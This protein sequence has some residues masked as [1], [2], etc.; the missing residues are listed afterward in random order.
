MP[1]YRMPHDEAAGG[2]DMTITRPKS[3]RDLA[4]EELRRRI[5]DGRIELGRGL[6]ENTLASE[7]GI[8]KTPIREALLHLKLEGLVDIQ[9]QRGTF[10]FRMDAAQVKQLSTMREILELAAIETA[11]ENDPAELADALTEVTGR[12]QRAIEAGDAALYRTLDG[13]FHQ[14]IVDLAGNQYLADAFQ[15]I[16]F[17]IQAL[18]NRLSVDPVLNRT[19]LDEHEGIVRRIRD[20]RAGGARKLMRAHIRGTADRY[21]GI[22]SVQRGAG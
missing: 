11:A 8:S 21:I 4:V 20:G 13:D 22:L 5:I 2:S 10:V 14:R 3:L 12:M 9:P 1:T 19:S 16:A 6:S 18:R 17:Q 7:L 15:G